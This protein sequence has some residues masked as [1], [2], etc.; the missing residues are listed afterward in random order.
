MNNHDDYN[1]DITDFW[2]ITLE[3]MG[4]DDHQVFGVEKCF[5]ED[6]VIKQWKQNKCKKE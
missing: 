3:K 6:L 5:N 2:N 4:G 1:N